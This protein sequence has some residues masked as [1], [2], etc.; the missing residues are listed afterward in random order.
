MDYFYNVF[1]ELKSLVEWTFSERA[2]IF[3]VSFKNICICALKING[4]IMR[5]K[6]HEGE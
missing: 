5:F 6:Q 4:S 1:N 3:Q 2:E